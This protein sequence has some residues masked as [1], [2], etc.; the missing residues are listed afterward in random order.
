[1]PDFHSRMSS[2]LRSLEEGADTV[3]WLCVSVAAKSQ[4]SGRFFEGLCADV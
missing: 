1:M 3:L 2:R 4:L